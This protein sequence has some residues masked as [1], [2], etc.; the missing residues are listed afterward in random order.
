MCYALKYCWLTRMT[1]IHPLQCLF[2]YM[3]KKLFG[4]SVPI[5]KVISWWCSD[6]TK[7]L[8]DKSDKS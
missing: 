1:F 2:K 8:S 7:Y 5:L 6:V 4:L 3:I